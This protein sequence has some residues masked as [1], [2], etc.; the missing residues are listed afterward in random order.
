[1]EEAQRSLEESIALHRQDARKPALA[2]TLCNLGYLLRRTA[3]EEAMGHFRESLILSREVE[4]PRTIAYCLGGGAIIFAARGEYTHATTLLG[5]AST[6][7]TQTGAVSS[8]GRREMTDTVEA[9]CRE[10]L[11]AEAFARAWEEGASLDAIA[12]AEWGLRLWVGSE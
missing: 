7:R 12:A 3:P 9:Q 6:I 8:P 5:A 10:E 2:I 11:S 4:E 1:M